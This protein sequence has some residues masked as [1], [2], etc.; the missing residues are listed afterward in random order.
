MTFILNLRSLY[1]KFEKLETEYSKETLG[2]GPV[3]GQH[4]FRADPIFL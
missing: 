1:I 2:E 3:P 4:D